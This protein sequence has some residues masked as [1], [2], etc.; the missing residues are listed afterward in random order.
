[1]S[2]IPK[3][4]EIPVPTRPKRSKKSKEVKNEPSEILEKPDSTTDPIVASRMRVGMMN[5]I[6]H[7]GTSSGID[8]A[9]YANADSGTAQ[10]IISLARYLFATD[11][12]SLPGI[13]TWQYNHPLP[14]GEGISEEVYHRL[15]NEVGLNESLQQ[16]YFKNR[17]AALNSGSGIAYDSTSFS[18][19]SENQ[20]EA[21]Y[22]FN[23][24]GDGLKTVKYVALYSIEN[25]Q[26]ITFTKQPGDLSDVLAIGN[27][28]NQLLSLGVSDAE[29]VTDNGYYSEYNISQMYQ[30]HFDFI[31]LAKTGLKWIKSEIDKHQQDLDRLSTVCPYDPTT[32]GITVML[33]CNFTKIRKYA[34]KKTGAVQGEEETFTRRVYLHIYYNATRKV[35]EDQAFER[36]LLSLKRRLEDGMSIDDLNETTQKKVKKYLIIRTWGKKRVIS[37]NEKACARAKQYHGYFTLVS[38]KEKETFIAL[39]KYRKREHIENY[40]RSSKQ[41]TDSMRLRVWNADTLR[42]RMF[43]QFIALCY[44]EY[45]SEAIRKMKNSLGVPNGNHDHDLKQNL[46]LE[47]R[48]KSWLGNTPIYL[49]LQWFDAIEGVEISSVLLSKRWTT[50]ITKRDNMFLEKLGLKSGF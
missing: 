29:I 19:Y 50:E 47:K 36:E 8:A 4:S 18:T 21:R 39:S 25:R 20:L 43:V 48:L 9:I 23:K 17:C 13:A 12:Q 37:F 30:A 34:N 33:M 11:G 35:D 5:I 42:G 14:Y 38:S 1:V 22:G 46:D 27:A 15:F 49:Q 32:Q 31:T 6:D 7:I 10:K 24:A 44:Y 16:N 45:Y 41:H 3:G 28:L 26:P 2:K 40:F